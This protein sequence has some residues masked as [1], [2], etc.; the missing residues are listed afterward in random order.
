MIRDTCVY[1]H[2]KHRGKYYDA[3]RCSEITPAA[4]GE[5]VGDD[6]PSSNNTNNNTPN[7]LPI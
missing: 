6:L 3:K 1:T 7:N 2:V 4:A 5:E